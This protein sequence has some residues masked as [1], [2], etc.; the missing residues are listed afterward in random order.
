[1]A[2]ALTAIATVAIAIGAT[3]TIFS[4]VDT[5]LLESLPY[6]KPN[7]LVD[8]RGAMIGSLGEAFALRERTRSFA[9]FAMYGPRTITLNDEGDATRIDGVSITPNLL[10]ILGVTPY[11]GGGFAPDASNPGNGRVMLLSHGLWIRRYGGDRGIVGRRVAVDGVP[12]TIIG[13]M[14]PRFQFPS[15]NAEF[16]TPL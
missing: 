16:W 14:P 7:E 15:T 9:D 11:I 2:F 3:T 5:L 10:P 12:Y 4:F 13:V 8:I 6:A 1:P